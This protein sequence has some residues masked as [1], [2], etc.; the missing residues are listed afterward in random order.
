[1][2]VLESIKELARTRLNGLD[3]LNTVIIKFDDIKDQYLSCELFQKVVL[4][5]FDIEKLKNVGY[6][7]QEVL[8]LGQ[9]LMQE[10]TEKLVYLK[11]QEYINKISHVN[12]QE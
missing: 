10:E 2:N 11:L 8:D 1:M 12:D 4:I 5:K 3:P 9:G 6:S 7:L